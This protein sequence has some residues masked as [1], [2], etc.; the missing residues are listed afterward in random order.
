MSNI[1]YVISPPHAN[2]SPYNKSLGSFE[3]TILTHK[4]RHLPSHGYNLRLFEEKEH[5]TKSVLLESEAIDVRTVLDGH[6]S[7]ILQVFFSLD[8]HIVTTGNSSERI[9]SVF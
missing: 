4:L 6:A 9:P 5:D 8:Y 3:T 7:F 1:F 2:S